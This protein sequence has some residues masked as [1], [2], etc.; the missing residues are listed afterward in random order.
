[1][2]IVDTLKDFLLQRSS[3]QMVADDPV[4]TAD[5]LLLVRMIFADGELKGDELAAFK[6]VCAEGFGIP[7]EEVGEVMR[8]LKEVGYETTGRQAAE[9]F[10]TM[11]HERKR[12]LLSHMMRIAIADRA[13]HASEVQLIE[14]VAATLGV[15]EEELRDIA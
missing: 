10:R 6:T 1:M 7:P 5:L 11:P 9:T 4:V 8:Y 15:S 2:S 3:V 14:K 13:L 12:K